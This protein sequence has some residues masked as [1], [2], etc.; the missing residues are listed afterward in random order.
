MGFRTLWHLDSKLQVGD[1]LAG[2]CED[3]AVLRSVTLSVALSVLAAACAL[4]EPPVPAGTFMVPGEVRNLRAAPV[5]LEVRTPAGVLPGAVQ[6]ASV[7]PGPSTAHVTYHLP[8]AGGW[9][10]AVN[11]DAFISSTDFGPDIREGCT[12]GIELSADGSSAHGCNV[13]P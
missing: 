3:D 8:I 4:V 12:L 6:P 7:P 9:S 13:W 5:T 11:G 1:F 2:W 10:I